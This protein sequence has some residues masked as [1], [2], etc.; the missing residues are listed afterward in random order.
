MRTIPSGAT[1]SHRGKR[2]TAGSGGAYTLP[3]GTQTLD[4]TSP[5][6]EQTRTA[7]SVQAGKS[8][9]ICYSFDTNSACGGT[10]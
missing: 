10:P 5:S 1:V 8:V 6:G 7:V 3:V 9:Q 2:L 4:I